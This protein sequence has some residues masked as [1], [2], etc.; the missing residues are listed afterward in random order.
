MNWSRSNTTLLRMLGVLCALC[1][2]LFVSG[3]QDGDLVNL[4]HLK[5]LTEPVTIDGRDMALVHI[6]AEGKTAEDGASLEA[7]FLGLVEE[8]VSWED[9][10][11]EI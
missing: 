9:E 5:Y 3:A 4:D 1:S 10:A 8:I 6:Y 2:V 7:E 11:E